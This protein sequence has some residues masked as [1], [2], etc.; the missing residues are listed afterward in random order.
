LNNTAAVPFVSAMS[1]GFGYDQL[2]QAIERAAAAA[3]NSAPDIADAFAS[4]YDQTPV[5]LPAGVLVP[6]SV[7]NE[8]GTRQ[9]E[10][11]VTRLPKARFLALLTLD[12]LYVCIGIGLMITA[13][14][15]LFFGDKVRDAQ[16]RLSVATVVAES[17][18]SPALGEDATS[19]GVLFAE[20]RGFKTRRVG[21]SKKDGG[22]RQYQQMICRGT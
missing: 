20:R 6:R 10:T 19:I 14:S 4:T 7:D 17:F 2:Q 21:L 3:E 13:L 11:L 1:Q 5:A 22:G 9:Y 15:A 12:M 18:E 8:N 16:A